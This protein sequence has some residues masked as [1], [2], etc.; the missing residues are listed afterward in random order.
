MGKTFKVPKKVDRAI[1]KARKDLLKKL[2]PA[3]RKAYEEKAR[4]TLAGLGAG[5]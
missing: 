3:E 2:T 1:E 4:R 5:W